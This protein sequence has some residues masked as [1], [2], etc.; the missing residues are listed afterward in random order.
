MAA[1]LWAPGESAARDVHLSTQLPEV[2]PN[3]ASRERFSESVDRDEPRRTLEYTLY[4][5][6]KRQ[7][8]YAITHY[9][10]SIVNTEQRRRAG[11]SSSERL[12]WHV[13][14]GVFRR[15]ECRRASPPAPFP[16]RWVELTP[17]SA[18]YNKQVVLLLEIYELQRQMLW[19]RARDAN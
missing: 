17:E 19:A 10:I 3:I 9:R 18:A 12:Q 13:S 5:D 6:P 4:V 2:L 7:A 1:S 8:L 11:V 15:F 16:C 14:N